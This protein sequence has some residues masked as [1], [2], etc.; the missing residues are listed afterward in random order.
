MLEKIYY[1]I[2]RKLITKKTEQ[3]QYSGGLWPRLVRETAS[4][5]VTDT[6]AKLI[7]LG[8]GEGLF[9]ELLAKK[10][11]KAEIYGV[12]I[13][14]DILKQAKNR[15]EG[16][17]IKL[18][19]SDAKLTK[20]KNSYF[21]CCF[22]INTILNLNSI[23]DIELLFLEVKRILKQDGLFIFDIR[24]SMNPFINL[25]Y[26]FVKFYDKGITVPVK[27]YTTNL[28]E[29]LLVKNGFIVES[30]KFIGFPN[31]CFAPVIL[32]IVKKS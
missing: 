1:R 19:L 14:K 29:E 7:E 21:D 30:K 28:I 9:L 20:L 5:I 18:I 6:T 12:D 11:P 26:K 16:L 25:Q 24:N 27:A 15:L 13:W 8:C 17:Q 4:K 10:N 32:F 2:I 3:N 23:Q 22:C 31:N